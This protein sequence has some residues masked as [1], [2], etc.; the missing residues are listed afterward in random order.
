[1]PLSES[2]PSI[3]EHLKSL[4]DLSSYNISIANSYDNDVYID[5]GNEKPTGRVI[6]FGNKIHIFKIDLTNKEAQVKHLMDGLI[7]YK[8]SDQDVEAVKLMI[9][10][11]LFLTYR[12]VGKC[13]CDCHKPNM[14][15][16]HAFPCCW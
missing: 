4:S 12:Q 2:Y 7:T 9:A 10:D 16:M 14:Q 3:V 13:K 8:M 1:M 11:S 15:I 6:T 5:F